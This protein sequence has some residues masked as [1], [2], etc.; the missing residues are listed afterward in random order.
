[1]IDEVKKK[2][3]DDINYKPDIRE[4][5]ILYEIDDKL[6]ENIDEYRK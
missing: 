3:D 4:L 6:L 1:M 5:K 2:L